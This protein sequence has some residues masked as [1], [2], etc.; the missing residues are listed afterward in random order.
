MAI[1]FSMAHVIN[2]PLIIEAAEKIQ[3]SSTP[4]TDI[5]QNRETKNK[6]A[7]PV[8]IEEKKFSFNKRLSKKGPELRFDM[9]GKFRNSLLTQGHIEVFNTSNSKRIQKIIIN[10]NFER[11][12]FDWDIGSFEYSGGK[13]QLVD[14]NFDG[15]R[16]LRFLDNEG[17]TGN[18][19]YASFLYD[20]GKGKFIFNRHLSSQSGLTVDTKN[21]QLLT[22]DRCGACCEFIKY[23]KY[24]DGQCVLSKIEWTEMDRTKEPGCF[25]ITG[26]SKVRDIE[27]NEEKMFDPDFSEYIKKRVKIVKRE[28]LTGSLDERQRGILGNTEGS[29]DHHRRFHGKDDW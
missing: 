13:V 20:P 3:V 14:L 16:D 6:E 11:G 17:A 24:R 27:I 18:N 7:A 4:L 8:K 15:Y 29:D 28:G 21:K 9:Y 2:E 12:H 26:I 22:Y 25:K 19:W 23:Y 1:F 10:N 5:S